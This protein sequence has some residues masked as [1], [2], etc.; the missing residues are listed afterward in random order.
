M[1]QAMTETIGNPLSWSVDAARATGHYIDAVAHQLGSGDTGEVVLPQVRRLAMSDLREALRKGVEDFAACRSDVIFLCLFFP[2]IG[3]TLAYMGLRGNLLPLVFPLVAGFTLVGPLAG[4]G[5]YEMS[6]R[7]ELGLETNWATAFAVVKSPSFAAIFVLGC[8]LFAIFVVWLIAAKGIWA[9]TL[10]PEL[11]TSI[12]SFVTEIFTTR[13]GWVMIIAGC[14]VGFLFAAAVLVISVVSFP[15]MLDRP[16]GLP[17]AVVTSMRVAAVNPGVI[18]AWGVLVAVALAI[19]SLPVFLGLV[20]V[21]P[22][23]GHATWH[24][25]RRAVVPPP[26]PQMPVT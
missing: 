12:G 15:L 8:V 13:A 19:G 14:G 21:L 18:A 10:G 5:L 11:P 26:A 1:E 23:L 4:T 24:L 17:V 7:R 20:V 9:I 22:V 3:L 16:V 25:Y 6:R 2:V